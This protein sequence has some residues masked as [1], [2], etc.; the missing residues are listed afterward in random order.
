MKYYSISN[1]ADINVIGKTYPQS[2]ESIHHFPKNI[3]STFYWNPNLLIP[4]DY[5]FPSPILDKR[6]KQTD[7][8]SHCDLSIFLLLVSEK[9]KKILVDHATE[10]DF[11]FFEALLKTKDGDKKFW[12]IMPLVSRDEFIDFERSVISRKLHGNA[13]PEL[14]HITSL[15]EYSETVKKEYGNSVLKIEKAIINNR[16]QLNFFAIM[17]LKN[18]YINGFIVSDHLKKII[19]GFNCTGIDFQLVE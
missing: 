16:K 12:G 7:L 8:I 10:N 2:Q 6:A 18:S 14:L 3:L 4:K 9:L 1:S 19:Q 13:E 5:L 11:Y 15:T 17:N